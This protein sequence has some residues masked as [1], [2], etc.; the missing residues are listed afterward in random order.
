MK[1]VDTLVVQALALSAVVQVALSVGAVY[2]AYRI[3]GIVGSF[4]AWTLV[5]VAFVLF[6]IRNVLSLLLIPFISPA[7]LA[8]II[9][10]ISTPTLLATQA[11]NIGAS[12]ILLLGMRSL[13]K[14]FQRQAR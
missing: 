9:G 12:V 10:V 8:S 1:M 7:A 6:T 3:T 14:M 5:I 13:A 11:V 2:Y 4:V